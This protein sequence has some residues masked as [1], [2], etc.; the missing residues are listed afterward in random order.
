[1]AIYHFTVAVISRARGQRI[2]AVAAS[3]AAAKLRDQYYG[4]LHNHERREGMEF[5]E[6]AAPAG[7]PPWVFD[8]E[9]LWNRVEAVERRKD[10]QLARAIEVS[11]P[12]E[13]DLVALPIS[14]AEGVGAEPLV[15]G[16][17]QAGG[18]VEAPAQ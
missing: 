7:S 14:E 5:T 1:M 18:G 2:V 10:S 12:V 16:H 11:L 4:V 13:L 3:H 6:I 8:R 9:Q 17:G 15:P